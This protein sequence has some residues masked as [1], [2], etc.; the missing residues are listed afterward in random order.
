[1][2]DGL[3]IYL[4]VKST[5]KAIYHTDE[6]RQPGLRRLININATLVAYVRKAE[7]KLNMNFG[8]RW[9]GF[10]SLPRQESHKTLTEMSGA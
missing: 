9:P 2:F 8:A 1:M 6:L 7:C 3:L 5:F 4:I 10:R